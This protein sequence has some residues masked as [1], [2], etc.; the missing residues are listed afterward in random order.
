MV[1][2]LMSYFSCLHHGN[3]QRSFIHLPT[4]RYTVS[5]KRCHYTEGKSCKYSDLKILPPFRDKLVFSN[6]NFSL[7]TLI[8]VL[9]LHKLNLAKVAIF[10]LLFLFDFLSFCF[11]CHQYVFSL[12]RDNSCNCTN[13]ETWIFAVLL[14]LLGK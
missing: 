11:V 8:P 6:R 2:P 13:H 5:E 4:N 10:Q 12:K 7:I 3:A 14:N 9:V 1:S